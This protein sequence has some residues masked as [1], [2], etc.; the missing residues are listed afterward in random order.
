MFAIVINL[1]AIAV[2]LAALAARVACKALRAAARLLC[3]AGVGVVAVVGIAAAKA[4]D[5]REAR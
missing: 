3:L 4:R 1:L 2:M 5:L